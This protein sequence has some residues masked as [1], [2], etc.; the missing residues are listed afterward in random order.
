[1]S[2]LVVQ[3]T[4]PWTYIG[5]R[6]V[7]ACPE[8]SFDLGLDIMAIRDMSMPS[9]LRTMTQLLAGRVDRTTGVAMAPRGRH[10]AHYHDLP[11]FTL[12]AKS[13]VGLQLDGDFIGE[14]DK[15][16]FTAVAGALRVL[17]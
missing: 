6:R 11:E 17:C 10:V 4:A 3:N 9:T 7:D 5:D 12:S 14:L 13:P 16:H 2:T 15:V 1:V 8:A